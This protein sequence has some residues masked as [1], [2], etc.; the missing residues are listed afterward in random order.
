MPLPGT[1]AAG[2]D[3]Q[4]GLPDSAGG[5]GW[6]HGVAAAGLPCGMLRRNSAAPDRSAYKSRTPSGMPGRGKPAAGEPLRPEL[7]SARAGGL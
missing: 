6:R 5:G 7:P 1:H 4:A 3:D 2:P